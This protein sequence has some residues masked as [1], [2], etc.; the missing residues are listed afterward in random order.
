MTDVT[1]AGQHPRAGA[2]PATRGRADFGGLR[3]GL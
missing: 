1:G 2:L 3:A